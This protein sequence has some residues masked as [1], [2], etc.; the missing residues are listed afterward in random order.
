MVDF[1]T[2][3]PYIDDT[4]NQ[5]EETMKYG[6]RNQI[7]ATVTSIKRGTVMAQLGLTVPAQSTMGSVMTID[8]LDELGIKNGDKVKLLIKAV[9]VIVVKET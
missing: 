1:L 7:S 6:V 2:L 4:L 9:N 5:E 3:M 8:S